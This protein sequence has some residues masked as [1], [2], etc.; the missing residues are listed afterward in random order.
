MSE[1]DPARLAALDQRLADLNARL[2][3]HLR[4]V[5][6]SDAGLVLVAAGLIAWALVSRPVFHLWEF[7][8]AWGVII[9]LA[10]GSFFQ[11]LMLRN[12]RAEIR[13]LRS[14]VPR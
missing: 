8:A 4:A 3:R 9:L 5:M 10:A 14:R 12:Y 6:R 11:G 2:D 13:D 7:V 1:P